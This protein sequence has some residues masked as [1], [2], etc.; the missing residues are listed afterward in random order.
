MQNLIGSISIS[1]FSMGNLER[2]PVRVISARTKLTCEVCLKFRSG[3]ASDNPSRLVI[4]SAAKL[5][6]VVPPWYQSIG[7]ARVI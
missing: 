7:Y 2:S 4:H 3:S 6:F 1:L 5:I